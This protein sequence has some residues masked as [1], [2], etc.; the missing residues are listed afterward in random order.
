MVSEMLFA[1][2]MPNG[3]FCLFCGHFQI[4]VLVFNEIMYSFMLEFI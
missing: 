1:S 4:F 3:L 2:K